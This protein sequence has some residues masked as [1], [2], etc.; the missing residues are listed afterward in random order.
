LAR[1]FSS[2]WRPENDHRHT[3]SSSWK[4]LEVYSYNCLLFSFRCQVR[5]LTDT[6]FSKSYLS[7]Y[8]YYSIPI[9]F[10]DTTVVHPFS[11]YKDRYR[12]M[13]SFPSWRTLGLGLSI[14]TALLLVVDGAFAGLDHPYHRIST[15]GGGGAAAT[16]ATIN[17]AATATT[18]LFST[19]ASSTT[20]TFLQPAAYDI[21]PIPIRIGHGF[22]IH[23]MAPVQE[24]GQPLVIGGVEIIHKDQKVSRWTALHCIALI[25]FL[26]SRDI[27][28]RS[29]SYSYSSYFCFHY[30]RLL[31]LLP[32]DR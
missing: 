15:T 24:A 20:T 9:L 16:T 10:P 5:I 18:A 23:R 7:P 17:V 11:N 25:R 1:P 13:T 14:A 28:K 32:V 29:Y 27:Y 12:T 31:L 26:R 3:R 30:S 8:T 6:P 22:D 21:E 2:C 4:Q 19:K